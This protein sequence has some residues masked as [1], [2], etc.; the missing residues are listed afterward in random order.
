MRMTPLCS[1]SRG[2]KLNVSWPTSLNI[3]SLRTISCES[4]LESIDLFC[5]SSEY[6]KLD[7]HLMTLRPENWTIFVIIIIKTVLDYKAYLR[8]FHAEI[9]KEECLF[10]Y[11]FLNILNI[12]YHVDPVRKTHFPNCNDVRVRAEHDCPCQKGR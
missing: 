3:Q 12:T 11:L 5:P 4:N 1:L 7:T 8:W 2:P 6:L 10:Q 9:L